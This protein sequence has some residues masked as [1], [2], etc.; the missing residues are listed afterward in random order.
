MF[1][2]E[3]GHSAGELDQVITNIESTTEE[4]KKVF[5]AK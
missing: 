5:L 4:L 3:C 2:L 1:P